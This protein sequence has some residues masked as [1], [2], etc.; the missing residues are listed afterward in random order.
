MKFNNDLKL[1][2]RNLLKNRAYALLNISGL[3]IGMAGSLLIFLIISY[4]LSTDSVQT[5]KDRVYRITTT[6][7]NDGNVFRT[8]GVPHPIGRAIRLQMPQA[9]KV[10]M[11]DQVGA[12]ISVRNASGKS[13][14]LFD[15]GVE[16]PEIKM[17]YAEPSLL[18]VLDYKVLSGN[19]AS[20]LEKPNLVVLT[21]SMS[22]KF[23]HTMQ[24]LG[25]TFDLDHQLHL[26][27]SAIIEDYQKNTNFPF[28]ALISYKSAH[29]GTDKTEMQNW[30][31]ISSN[32]GCLILAQPGIERS[33]LEKNLEG[34]VKSHYGAK[35]AKTNQFH[36]QPLKE[37]RLDGTL[38]NYAYITFPLSL[39][40][41]LGSIGLVLLLTACI[42]FIN[43]STAIA[44]KR[45]RE[46]G[47]KKVLGSTPAALFWQ[48]MTE[49]AVTTFLSALFALALVLIFLPSLSTYFNATVG[50]KTLVSAP[51][52]LFFLV[53]FLLMVFCAGFYPGKILSGFQAIQALKSQSGTGTSRGFSLRKVLVVV[54]F[55]I[56]QVMIIATLVMI[57]QMNFIHNTDL[58]FEKSDLYLVSLPT[59][60]TDKAKL[61]REQLKSLSGVKDVSL[62]LVSPMSNSV[63]TTNV[64]YAG[65]ADDEKFG[66]DSFCADSNYLKTYGIKLICGRNIRSAD[67]ATEYLVNETF[68]KKLGLKN[69]AEVL[70]KNLK[71]HRQTA[72][73]V[74]VVRDF[75]TTSFRSRIPS[76]YISMEKNRFRTAGIKISASNLR[77]EKVEIERL[78]KQIYPGF[79]YQGYFFDEKVASMHEDE[80]KLS[81]II[82]F[83]AILA[84]VIGSLGLFGLISFTVLHKTKEIGIRKVHGA[85]KA[86]IMIGMSSE[87]A[88]LLLFAFVAAAPLAYWIMSGWL[89]DF[90]FRIK[91]EPLVFLLALSLSALI[92]LLTIG[93]KTY[94]AATANPIKSL[95]AE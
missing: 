29:L 75:H 94:Q 39:I 18:D 27:V 93:F 86:S 85:G 21:K 92:T 33:S 44:S 84:I 56:S 48:F 3:S 50:V 72:P 20:A 37:I 87:F 83:F 40:F 2:W 24:S 71:V 59:F 15:G 43:L 73:I 41:S 22:M 47:I 62:S 69:P 28:D 45:A 53:V 42:N 35:D 14:T 57:G 16:N 4:H 8:S 76:L 60:E 19:A 9:E 25:K 77:T 64:N 1:A 49:T 95:R 88:W 36:A 51:F 31:G 68:V 70:G 66:I 90:K 17:A 79:I 23:F 55:A 67:S 65:R 91:I 12:I 78:W 30:G 63:S 32:T 11:L 52:L 81:Q 6:I 89:N 82:R 38:S 34:L 80:D 61:F 10:V 5:K 74:G 13:E 7:T 54:Q 26:Q 58:G 46:V